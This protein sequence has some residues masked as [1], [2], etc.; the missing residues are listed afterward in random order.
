MMGISKKKIGAVCV[1]AGLSY[2]II[3]TLIC[4]GRNY[5]AFRLGRKHLQN[6]KNIYLTF[7]DG[8]G[9][10]TEEILAVLRQNHVK[11]AFFMVSYFAKE[12]PEI[13]RSVRREGHTIG[14]HS[15]KHK[16]PMFEGLLRS[17]RDLQQGYMDMQDLGIPVRMFRP[18]WGIVNASVLLWQKQHGLD[19]C[20]WNV[21]AEDWRGDETAKSI[22]DKLINRVV[23][24]CIICLHDGRGENAA[25]LRTAKALKI[26][27]P[28]LKAEGYRFVCL[29]KEE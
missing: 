27:I 6:E 14:M 19:M 9:C 17:Y 1:L 25:P 13:V 10:Y 16:N 3:P 28:K 7:D 22:A 5:L 2:S 11:A 26:A 4:R 29:G 21:M 15:R 12:H 20:L 8:P 24:G 23:P 18:P